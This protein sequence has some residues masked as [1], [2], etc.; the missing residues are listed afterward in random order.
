M[1]KGT[2][3]IKIRETD[4]SHVKVVLVLLALLV[5]LVLSIRW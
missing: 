5:L 1:Y 3:S 2:V 4:P